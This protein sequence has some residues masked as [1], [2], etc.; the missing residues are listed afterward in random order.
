MDGWLAFQNLLSFV[1]WLVGL[2]WLP[3]LPAHL[4]FHGLRFGLSRA[5]LRMIPPS[6]FSEVF[7]FAPVVYYQVSLMSVLGRSLFSSE[8]VIYIINS[9]ISR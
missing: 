1:M 6:L 7:V 8:G 2:A 3:S 5:F 9:C 4:P